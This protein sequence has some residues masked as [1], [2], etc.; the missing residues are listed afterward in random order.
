MSIIADG[1]LRFPIGS[2]GCQKAGDEC[3]LRA[4]SP[5]VDSTSYSER[6][7]G[8]SIDA[9]GGYGIVPVQAPYLPRR[10]KGVPMSVQDRFDLTAR[11]ASVLEVLALRVRVLSIRQV[12]RTW[13]SDSSSADSRASR[14]IQALAASGLV[15]TYSAWVRPELS[16]A[17]PLVRWSPGTPAPLF[18]D[19][20]TQLARRWSQPARR[21]QLVGASRRTSARL[22]GVTNH[23]PRRSEVSHD[24]TLAGIYLRYRQTDRSIAEAWT[25]D[26]RLRRLG[27]GDHARLPDALIDLAG[28]QR[29]VE[30]GGTYSARK[31]GEFHEFCE[32]RGLPYEIW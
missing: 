22:A 27:F 18:P 11:D 24:L 15:E 23:R 29:V 8:V 14:R 7:R 28:T 13:F 30:L 4:A 26:F 19:L 10:R 21:T 2:D 25:P 16:L 6:L 9:Q 32:S 1:G 3:R 5:E 20:A 17:D 31:L 12:S